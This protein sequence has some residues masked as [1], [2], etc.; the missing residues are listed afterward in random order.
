MKSEPYWSPASA[1][2]ADVA[3]EETIQLLCLKGLL[4]GC[5]FRRTQTSTRLQRLSWELQSCFVD[6][7]GLPR[8]KNECRPERTPFSFW[9]LLHFLGVG[10]FPGGQNVENRIRQKCG[11]RAR[12]NRALLVADFRPQYECRPEGTTFIFWILVDF[13]RRSVFVG[14]QNVESILRQSVG[15]FE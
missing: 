14:G 15:L 11:F 8:P 10:F 9:I 2:R 4:R 7:K 6:H 5:V 1:P 13:L 12:G 3:L